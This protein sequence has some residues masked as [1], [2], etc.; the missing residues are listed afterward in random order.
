[1]GRIIIETL[2]HAY[3]MYLILIILRYCCFQPLFQ[4]PMY[5]QQSDGSQQDGDQ[6]ELDDGQT[7]QWLEEF[8]NAF[9]RV[10][11]CH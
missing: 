1:M 11:E 4:L 5:I 10:S 3:Q 7:E 9:D 8:I 2:G 6:V